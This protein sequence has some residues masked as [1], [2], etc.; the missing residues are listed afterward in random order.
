MS[1]KRKSYYRMVCV[2]ICFM[3]AFCSVRFDLVV[4]AVAATN[5]VE[6]TEC[7]TTLLVDSSW[8]N[9][10][11][12]RIVIANNGNDI[13]SDWK[14]SFQ[15]EDVIYSVWNGTLITSNEGFYEIECLDWN[16]TI[17]PGEI[18]EIGLCANG[19]A[20][21]ITNAVV[22]KATASD[23]VEEDNENGISL[24][25]FSSE[26]YLYEADGY[27]VEYFIKD[28]WEGCC[29]VEVT[30]TNTSDSIIDNWNLSFDT[31]DTISQVY[32]AEMVELEN[33]YYFSNMGYNQ[34]ILVGESITF[35]FQVQ[36]D[37]KLDIPSEYSINV[38]EN[39]IEEESFIFENIITNQWEGGYTGELYITN[40]RDVTIED[41]YLLLEGKDEFVNVWNAT[42]EVLENQ[43]YGFINPSDRQNILP[44]ETVCIGYQANGNQSDSIVAVS[45]TEKK[46][47]DVEIE[48]GAGEETVQDKW[49]VINDDEFIESYMDNTY[50]VEEKL[51]SLVGQA[52]HI[53]EIGNV[54]YAVI[55]TMENVV[56]EGN[57]IFDETNK[58]Q[59]KIEDFGLAV[60]YNDVVFTIELIDESY[61]QETIGFIN[62]S[63]DNM[64]HIYVD[65]NDN[66][67]DGINNYYESFY[68]TDM[69][70]SDTDGD[71]LGDYEE[72]IFIGTDPA[73]YDTDGNGI[74]DGE[75]D[76]DEDGL[77]TIEESKL[78]TSAN[79]ADSDGDGLD[80]GYEVSVSLTKPLLYD[81]DEDT[82]SDAEELN[83]GLNPL[84]ADSD[85]NGVPDYE[86]NILQSETIE[87]TTENSAVTDVT[88]NISAEGS[89]DG[90]VYIE[91]TYETDTLSANVVGLVGCPVSIETFVEFDTAEIV[92]KY[93]EG[94]LGETDE[95]DLCVMWYDE[96]NREYILL[97]DSVCDTE[98]NT[99]SYVTTHFSTYLLVDKQIWLDTMRQN[100]DYSSYTYTDDEVV[101]YDIIIALDYT[102]SEEEVKEQEAIANKIIDGMVEGDRVLVFYVT[103]T[104][105]SVRYTSSY[106]LDW[107]TTQE[108]ARAALDPNTLWAVLAN[109]YFRPS[110]TYD[111]CTE[112]AFQAI[113]LGMAQVDGNE[114][115]A[116]VFYPGKWYNEG[117]GTSKF[118]LVTGID[119]AV[120]EGIK[121]HTISLGDSTNPYIDNQ[122]SRTGGESFIATTTD[123]L[124]EL[125]NGYLKDEAYGQNTHEVETFDYLDSDGDGLYD[126]YEINGMRIQ[127]GTVAYT[128]PYN[129]DSDGDGINDYNELGG[130]P[131]SWI[132]YTDSREFTCVINKQVS[133]PNDINS[134][135]RAL[136]GRYVF[137]EDLYQLPYADL[138]YRAIFT[139]NTKKLDSNGYFIYGLCNIF[140]SNLQEL[141]TTEAQEIVTEVLTQCDMT[142][143]VFPNASRNLR[144]YISAS[145]N[146][147]NF[148]ALDAI[149]GCDGAYNAFAQDMYDILYAAVSYLEPNE[150]ITIAISPF[151]SGTGV[152]ASF[153]DSLD[154]FFAMLAAET[155]VTAT[156]SYDGSNYNIHFVYYIFDYYDWDENRD[157]NLSL[158]NDKQMYQLC[159][160]GSGKFYE[161]WG[162]Y[163][164]EYQFAVPEN[165]I[166]DGVYINNVVL[167]LQKI[168]LE[169]ASGEVSEEG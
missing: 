95:N 98:N 101:N 59:W 76:N 22:Y 143:D 54:T 90:K 39:T 87:I 100:I 93:D 162:V 47:F 52:N 36:Y 25:E 89:I 142:K 74:S 138:T 141:T 15:C 131:N 80:D 159:R 72:I 118:N 163:E 97:E 151:S 46:D 14:L 26:A 68:G 56:L 77:N 82:Y 86:E 38:T 99:V 9:G 71:L 134:V 128:D 35:G 30:I 115:M 42:L 149:E 29:N 121:V 135:G 119:D 5:I 112:L 160:C 105:V 6:A 126:T 122:I 27:T 73:R 20:Q 130:V 33:G 139:E 8:E 62:M 152:N 124:K 17:N 123:E 117:N 156:I 111:A 85:S 53:D 65:L 18:I 51:L 103:T 41:W 75:E 84:L 64:Q 50:V 57:I 24:S 83:L 3:V 11:Q 78:G 60:G 58:S 168:A 104:G 92:F 165:G 61:V 40:N 55:D 106:A 109:Q 167:E 120:D 132:Y 148:N 19:I 79:V 32:E 45:L 12:G 107:N 113:P 154:W 34:D 155:R 7:E 147:Y 81:T 91:N 13:V 140:E 114:K 2:I 125:I 4:H 37:S 16:N 150:E 146:K 31:E 144:Q 21:E 48:D 161:N 63:A 96:E 166:I 157:V 88:V 137:V 110:E 169:E 158:V 70:L 66:D 129:S 116:F 153:T 23:V 94:M 69:N 43:Q 133:D 136:D 10:Y 164:S 145:A 28:A 49:I 108:E 127:N 1:L 44:G 102:M 67:R